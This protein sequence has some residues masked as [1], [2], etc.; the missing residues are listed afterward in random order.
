M[1]TPNHQTSTTTHMSISLTVADQW[2]TPGACT[3]LPPT[4]GAGRHGIRLEP[5]APFL[6]QAPAFQPVFPQNPIL[7]RMLKP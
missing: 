7:H 5:I 3:I 1:N 4:R 2:K 6:S